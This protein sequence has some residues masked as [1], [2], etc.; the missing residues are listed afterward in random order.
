MISDFYASALIV[1]S[2]S[3][4]KIHIIGKSCFY[5]TVALYSFCYLLNSN[6]I[7][8]E[9]DEVFDELLSCSVVNREVN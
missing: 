7:S 6:K 5:P 4:F 9:S 1:D 2:I 3:L 8:D